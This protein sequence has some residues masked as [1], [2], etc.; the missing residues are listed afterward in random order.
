MLAFY[1]YTLC[2][3]YTPTERNLAEPIISYYWSVSPKQLLNKCVEVFFQG[4]TQQL[5]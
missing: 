1:L 5:N 4:D 3:G 2:T